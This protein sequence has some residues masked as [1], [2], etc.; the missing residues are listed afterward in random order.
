MKR[1]KTITQGLVAREKKVSRYLKLRKKLHVLS[2]EEI[3]E[4][5]KLIDIIQSRE[6]LSNKFQTGRISASLL[7]SILDVMNEEFID[8]QDL[9]KSI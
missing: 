2:F 1:K 4:R 6:N 3:S 7:F 5:L 8:L 9:N